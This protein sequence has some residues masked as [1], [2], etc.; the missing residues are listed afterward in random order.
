MKTMSEQIEMIRENL[1]EET[2]QKIELMDELARANKR[3]HELEESCEC[4]AEVERNLHTKVKKLKEEKSELIVV[5]SDL[6]RDCSNVQTLIS[7]VNCKSY[8][9]AV[10]TLDKFKISEGEGYGY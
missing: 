8:I 7:L 3:N 1:D 6:I 4:F 2:L 5:L 9:N 10:K